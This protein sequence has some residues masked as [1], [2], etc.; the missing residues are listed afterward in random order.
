[1]KKW[2]EHESPEALGAR[3]PELE[4]AAA[5]AESALDKNAADRI[6]NEARRVAIAAEYFVLLKARTVARREAEA[7]R[8]LIEEKAG[9]ARRAKVVISPAEKAAKD[10]AELAEIVAERKRNY[11]GEGGYVPPVAPPAR[12]EHD[13]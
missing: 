3:L 9:R 4:K 6:A 12:G 7:V 11:K 1:M 8:D 2:Y 13:W 10:A 5:A